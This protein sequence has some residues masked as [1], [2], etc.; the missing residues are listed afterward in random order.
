M[1]VKLENQIVLKTERI[2]GIFDLD[3]ATTSRHT[4]KFLA[5]EE[6]KGKVKTLCADLP[7]AFI[8]LN[9]GK[10][11]LTQLSTATIAKRIKS[12]II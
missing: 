11:Y 10:I 7:K 3:N 8:L 4:R 2:V 9:D 6:K 1:Y 5:N 12:G